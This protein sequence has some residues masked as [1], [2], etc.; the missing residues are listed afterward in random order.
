M[1]AVKM[2]HVPSPAAPRG[3]DNALIM[4]PTPV[5]SVHRQKP[6]DFLRPKFRSRRTGRAPSGRRRMRATMRCIV[7]RPVPSA[8]LRGSG[9]DGCGHGSG[10][11]GRQRCSQVRQGPGNAPPFDP[12]PPTYEVRRADTGAARPW[13]A[14]VVKPRRRGAYGCSPCAGPLYGP[15]TFV[16]PTHR[17][18]TDGRQDGVAEP[19]SNGYCKRVGHEARLAQGEHDE[20][21][22]T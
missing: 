6:A 3:K 21:A 14:A 13:I 8:G 9:W 4:D 19:L 12:P 16:V 18:Q 15:W 22:A 7:A 10:P 11:L 1:P 5:Y 2:P 17:P 20:A